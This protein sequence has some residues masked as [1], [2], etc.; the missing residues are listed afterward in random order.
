ML[1]ELSMISKTDFIHSILLDIIMII[2]SYI[3]LGFCC[4]YSKR[5]LL[6]KRK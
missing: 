3:N 2:K 6:T 1:S 4:T 5:T